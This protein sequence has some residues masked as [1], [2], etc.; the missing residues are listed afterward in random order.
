LRAYFKGVVDG[1][2]ATKIG[3]GSE[4]VMLLDTILQ[5]P[6]ESWAVIKMTAY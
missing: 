2:Q 5:K 6:A 1:W 3:Y 4:R